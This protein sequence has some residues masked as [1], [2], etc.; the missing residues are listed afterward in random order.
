M[1]LNEPWRERQV[2]KTKTRG[3]SEKSPRDLDNQKR[4]GL[5]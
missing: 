2:E 3:L 1:R 4:I 5:Q